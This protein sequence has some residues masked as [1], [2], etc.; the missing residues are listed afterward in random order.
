MG[1]YLRKRTGRY[2]SFS[3]RDELGR[4]KTRLAQLIAPTSSL[5]LTSAPVDSLEFKKLRMRYLRAEGHKAQWRCQ[6]CRDV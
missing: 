2:P 6:K 5:T 1:A 4:R 3:A